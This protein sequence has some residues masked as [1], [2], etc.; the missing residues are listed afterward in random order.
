MTGKLCRMCH[1]RPIRSELG[2]ILYCLGCIREWQQNNGMV[3][4]IFTVD[5]GGVDG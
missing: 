4:P 5:G 2:Y 1:V 3:G